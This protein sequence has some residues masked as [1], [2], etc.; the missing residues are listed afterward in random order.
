MVIAVKWKEMVGNFLRRCNNL[1]FSK[2][3]VNVHVM[4]HPV[5]NLWIDNNFE[6]FHFRSGHQFISYFFVCAC[7][8][9]WVC[10]WECLCVSACVRECVC[11][12]VCLFLPLCSY[13]LC[14]LWR[15]V[16][17]NEN[18]FYFM[19]LNSFFYCSTHTYGVKYQHNEP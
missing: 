19:F 10:V 6:N 11:M 9:A 13:D 16:S 14:L 12:C 8:C 2:K 18:L 1:R 4:E 3:F 5:R 15:Y 7:V 17:H